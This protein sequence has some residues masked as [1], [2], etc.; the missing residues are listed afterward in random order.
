MAEPATETE[1]KKNQLA[2]L[3]Q[4]IGTLY[5]IIALFEYQDGNRTGF[6]KLNY[7]IDKVWMYLKKVPS[8]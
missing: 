5:K 8:D 4:S 1:I 7:I 6:M 3:S 2:S